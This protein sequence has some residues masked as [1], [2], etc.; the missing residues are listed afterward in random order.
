MTGISESQRKV[1]I[2]MLQKGDDRWQ[3]AEEVGVS[4]QTVSAIKAHL[5]MGTYRE[6]P[7]PATDELI[8]AEETTFGLERDL[9]IA[10]RSN[11]QQLEEGLVVI[12]GGKEFVTE[13]GR[14]DIL[15]KDAAGTI[16]VIELKAGKASP[17]ALTQLLAYIGVIGERGD[18]NVRGILVAADFHPRIVFAVKA[19]PSVQL[20]RYRFRFTFE[21]VGES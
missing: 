19:I 21:P 14:I 15:A 18:E 10:L 3:I 11:I 4:P 5:T 13:A 7:S 12:D 9:Q 20:R 2:S 1:I 16:V 17:Q 6:I 8:D